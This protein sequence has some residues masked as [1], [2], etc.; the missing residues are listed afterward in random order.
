MTTPA[1]AAAPPVRW[2]R[3]GDVV[4]VPGP[5]GRRAA[6]WRLAEVTEIGSI[7]PA[8]TPA[9]WVTIRGTDVSAA[10]RSVWALTTENHGY[11]WRWPRAF[12]AAAFSTMKRGRR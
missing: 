7:E 1:A 6:A 2:P 9:F 8:A 5:S 4:E 12:S 10:G 11:M 3:F